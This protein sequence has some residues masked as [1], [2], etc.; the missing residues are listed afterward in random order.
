MR[1]ASNLPCFNRA[2]GS[3]AGFSNQSRPNRPWKFCKHILSLL[4]CGLLD[5]CRTSS[6]APVPAGCY[7]SAHRNIHTPVTAHPLREFHCAQ[8]TP[9]PSPS[10]LRARSSTA[11]VCTRTLLWTRSRTSDTNALAPWADCVLLKG[12]G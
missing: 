7:H 10:E 12:K 1:R 11:V 9:V 8:R 5:R 2:G 3:R 4:T 6:P